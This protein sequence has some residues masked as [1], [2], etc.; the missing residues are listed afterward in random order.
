VDAFPDD[1]NLVFLLGHQLWFDG[2]R[3]EARNQF[4]KA[5]ALAKGLTPAEAFLSK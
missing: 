3:E 1:A 4:R 5:A 2:K